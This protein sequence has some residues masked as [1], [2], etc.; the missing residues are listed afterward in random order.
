MPELNDD[1]RWKIAGINHMAWLL[2][3]EDKAGNDLYP[4]LK[5]R[6]NEVKPEKDLV[7]LDIMNRF[8]YYNTESSEMS[9]F[10]K[11][12]DISAKTPV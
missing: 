2:E 7:R 3:I 4:A 9:C 1:T 5:K 12:D 10:A 8:G 11:Q 6:F